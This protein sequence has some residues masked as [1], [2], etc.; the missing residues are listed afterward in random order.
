VGLGDA[1]TKKKR[2]VDVPA[3]EAKARESVRQRAV[4]LARL[5]CELWHA[6]ENGPPQGY[7]SFKRDGHTEHVELRTIAGRLWVQGLFYRETGEALSRQDTEQVIDALEATA[8]HEGPRLPVHVR[9]ADLG[10][11]TYLD[12]A[13]DAWRVVEV[14]PK[15]P[16]P[17]YQV[18]PSERAPVRFKRPNGTEAL[19]VPAPGGSLEELKNFIH[20]DAPGLAL[21]SV[22]LVS[23]MT[24]RGSAVLLSFMGGQ[25]TSKSTSTRIFQRLVDPR[26]GALRSAPK[27]DEDLAVAARN[28]WVVSYDNFSRISPDLSDSLCRLATGAAFT[29]RQLYTNGEE[30][31]YA[32][33]RP[34]VLNSITDIV[35]RADLLDRT[36]AVHLLK[37]TEDQRQEESVFWPRFEEARP[38][39]LGAALSALSGALARWSES[40]PERLPRLSDFYH[41]AHAMGEAIPG[42]ADAF[43]E[44][45]AAMQGDAIQSALDASPIGA[46]LLSILEAR[47]RWKAPAAE[48]LRELNASRA[49][50]FREHDTWPQTPHGLSSALRRLAPALEAKGWH[51]ELGL[52]ATD[53]KHERLVVI[54]RT[55]AM[56]ERAAIYQ[57]DAGMDVGQAER[58]AALDAAS[59]DAAS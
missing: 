6:H 4:N 33:R 10:D 42:G 57:V 3:G 56:A 37:I 40:R 38:R 5:N 12:L 45:W 50:G 34:V 18:I 49:A 8:I 16:A 27:R 1:L 47:H 41:L 43:D 51:L 14:N 31:V 22:C 58:Q 11:R 15:L 28:S 52:R 23:A 7:A 26:G 39:L 19:P 2:T 44:A 53:T 17:G 46:A 20:T 32:A 29:G 21:V 30:V 55:E 54:V 48:L 13:D 25:G 59:L 35:N 24:D 9:V 36:V